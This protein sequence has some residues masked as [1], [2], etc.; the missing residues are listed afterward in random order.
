MNLLIYLQKRLNG[1]RNVV[2]Y[3]D[4]H[5]SKL[6]NGTYIQQMS[7]APDGVLWFSGDQRGRL[8]R[9]ARD[10]RVHLQTQLRL[11]GAPGR[12]VEPH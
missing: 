7:A 8:G 4:S 6:P 1:H 2:S 3:I 11:Q 9:I 12:G 5:A 10:G